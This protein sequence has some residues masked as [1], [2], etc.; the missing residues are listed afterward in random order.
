MSVRAVCFKVFI[1]LILNLEKVNRTELYV[2]IY[3]T[4]MLINMLKEDQVDKEEKF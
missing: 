1:Y 2:Q 4:K 3:S